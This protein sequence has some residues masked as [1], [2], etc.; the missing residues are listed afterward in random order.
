MWKRK[1]YLAL[2]YEAVMKLSD[3]LQSYRAE[4]FRR[5]SEIYKELAAEKDSTHEQDDL[6]INAGANNAQLEWKGLGD[7]VLQK[8]PGREDLEAFETAYNAA[9]GSIARGELNQAE[10][11][12]KR[13]KGMSSV[14]LRFSTS[15]DEPRFMPGVGRA[16]TAR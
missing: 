12:L 9:C 6:R 4:N 16:Y 5:T 11:L 2:N 1:L 10:V 15:S 13:S 7:S 14:L 3:R 8:K